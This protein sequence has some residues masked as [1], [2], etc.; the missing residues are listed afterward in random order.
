MRVPLGRRQARLALVCAIVS[1]F[2]SIGAHAAQLAYLG[3]VDEHGTGLG[4]V[5][6]VLSIGRHGVESGCV[7]WNGSADVMGP[8]APA[9]PPGISGGDEK[10][11]AS[12][13]LTR[14]LAE[15]GN[16]TAEEL[17]IIF[18]PN[19]PGSDRTLRLES[20]VLRIFSPTGAVLLEAALPTPEGTTATESSIASAGGALGRGTATRD[21][22]ILA[23]GENRIGLAAT[24]SGADGGF[25]TFYVAQSESGGGGSEAG[26]DTAPRARAAA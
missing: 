3:P 4:N 14:R 16:P 18:N 9:C 7:A 19:E 8:G 6:T 20:L 21:E 1:T 2:T 15:V 26:R 10:T 13:T 22:T 23:G 11:G 12:Q 24:I 5:A 17:R 25:E